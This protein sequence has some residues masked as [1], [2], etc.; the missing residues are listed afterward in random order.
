[1]TDGPDNTLET[2][3]ARIRL[4]LMRE[5]ETISVYEA[6]ARAAT[7]P[8]IRAFFQHLAREEKEHVAEATYL[9]RKLDAE[10]NA[11]FD[12]PFSEA[13]FQGGAEAHAAA[14]PVSAAPQPEPGPSGTEPAPNI[15]GAPRGVIGSPAGFIP[16][17]FRVPESPHATLYAIPAPPSPT[18]GAFTV[19]PLKSRR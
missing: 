8:E 16:E 13:H 2:D 12:K 15:N 1:M 14:A 9:L 7:A 4:V 10:Q 19:G 17:D 18:A 3:V 11:D 6:L 5:L